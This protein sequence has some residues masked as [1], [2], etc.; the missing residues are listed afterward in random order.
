MAQKREKNQHKGKFCSLCG[1]VHLVFWN[2]ARGISRGSG[3]NYSNVTT[4]VRRLL[5]HKL[6]QVISIN[7]F[8]IV[9]P[10]SLV[11]VGIGGTIGQS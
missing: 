11:I 9:A 2:L 6:M 1:G 7:V 5:G 8:T 3:S 10:W 4:V